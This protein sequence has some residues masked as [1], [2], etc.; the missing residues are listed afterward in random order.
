MK[1]RPTKNGD[2]PVIMVDEI[3]EQKES[4]PEPEPEQRSSRARAKTTVAFLLLVTFYEAFDS[5]SLAVALPV[6][7]FKAHL[8]QISW[9]EKRC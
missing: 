9:K 2:I 5:T 6:S 8:V 4:E 3:V 1:N 7:T